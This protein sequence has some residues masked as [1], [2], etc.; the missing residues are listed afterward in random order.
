MSDY[1]AKINEVLQSKIRETRVK[2]DILDWNQERKIDSLE[3]DVVS[4]NISL[5]GNSAIRRTLNLVINITKTE[6]NYVGKYNR[7]TGSLQKNFI[8]DN[9]HLTDPANKLS[10]NKKV[11]I[12]IGVK[13][14]MKEYP[15]V[16]E[17]SGSWSREHD[18]DFI[19]Y[20]LGIYIITKP[21]VTLSTSA[22]QIS[23]ALQDK[24]CL[25]NGTVGGMIDRPTRF[26]AEMIDS[27]SLNST[28]HNLINGISGL[29]NSMT[30]LNRVETVNNIKSQ[31][32]NNTTYS[33]I[34]NLDNSAVYS[35]LQSLN[36]ISTATLSA[37]YESAKTTCGTILSSLISS[38]YENKLKIRDI[39][40]YAATTF[41]GEAP[42]KVIISDVPDFIK[43]PVLIPKDTVLTNI[44]KEAV[45]FTED[46][47]GYKMIKYTYPDKMTLNAGE[48]VSKVY[49]N[50][51]SALG[52]N[53]QYY[54]DVNGY[55][56]FE[57]IKNYK[58]N[59]TPDIKELKESDYLKKY[60]Q[61]AV[62]IDF[63]SDANNISYNNTIDYTNIKN[64][65][66]VSNTVN[67]TFIGYH[68]VIDSKPTSKAYVVA[69]DGSFTEMDYREFIVHNYNSGTYK[70]VGRA[71]E[72][73][74]ASAFIQNNL[75]LFGEGSFTLCMFISGTSAG[76]YTYNAGTMTKVNIVHSKQLPDYYDELST[77]WKNEYYDANWNPITDK[78]IFNYNFEI[79][80]AD[81]SL[82]QFSVSS[83]G[84]RTFS[85]TDQSIKALM[86]TTTSDYFLVTDTIKNAAEDTSYQKYWFNAAHTFDISSSNG[87]GIDGYTKEVKYANYGSIYNDAFSAVRELLYDKTGYNTQVSITTLPYYWLDV[88]NRAKIFYQPA[89]IQGFY[90]INKISYNID[91]TSIMTVSL[92]EAPQLE[93]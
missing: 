12:F 87:D 76:Y 49:D 39:I 29:Y 5:D 79:L 38:L 6:D 28:T 77:L 73:S 37:D 50:C 15:I 92:T 59:R 33:E 86:P 63:S 22:Q 88:N 60:N 16:Q 51:N 3:G 55:F 11:K 30:F 4:G 65:I 61:S 13:D 14:L 91:E 10:L 53:Y 25:H 36:T 78:K 70:F 89:S 17:S 40:Y 35:L 66:L 75:N 93:Q 83:I 71:Y 34:W 42:G 24:G 21:T 64:D 47:I 80:D 2:I 57:E 46:T 72:V 85:K 45:T 69:Q 31:Y 44:S 68:V 32:L 58:Y 54:Y 23:I 56:H 8:K 1:D 20:N 81:S 43:C 7:I 18:E 9:Y 62:A 19:W 52:G 48:A 82:K 67:G 41:G 27:S 90:L 74:K 84:R 26:D